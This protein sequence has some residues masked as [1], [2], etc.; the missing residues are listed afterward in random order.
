MNRHIYTALWPVAL[1]FVLA[2]LLWRSRAEPAYRQHWGERWGYYTTTL[3]GRVIWL[4]AV[5]VGETRATEPLVRALLERGWQ[6]LLTHMTPGGKAAA[7]QLFAEEIKLKKMVSAYLPYD[8][9]SAVR[10]FLGHFRPRAGLFVDTEIW[11][12]ALAECHAQGIKTALVNA[13]LSEKSAVRGR[14]LGSLMH[15]AAANL[16]LAAAQTQSDSERLQTF[17]VPKVVVTGNLKFDVRLD[18]QQVA[19]GQRWRDHLG[20]RPVLVLASTRESAG[21]EEE[22]LWFEALAQCRELPPDFLLVVVPRHSQRFATVAAHARARGW[23]V[24][25]RSQDEL[26]A[27][28]TQLWLGDSMGELGA[29]YT[30]ADLAFV[31]GSL[32]PLG[33]QNLIEA[34]AYGC[35]VLIGPSTFN[36]AEATAQAVMAGAAKRIDHAQAGVQVAVALLRDGP[37]RRAMRQAA[38]TFCQEHRGATERTLRALS[39]LFEAGLLE[40]GL[41]ESELPKADDEERALARREQ[42]LDRL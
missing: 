27:P 1:P 39:G 17:G 18:P 10:R 25:Q 6:V 33:G 40:P 35:P 24:Q 3:S 20:S 32:L 34:C 9:P 11:P 28:D 31:G 8:Y 7:Q 14:R 37:A 4:H 2:R 38:L 12:N 23:R 21:I 42:R 15:E 41:T 19:R 30:L 5:S 36:F 29:Y 16:N 26:V 13:R 22:V